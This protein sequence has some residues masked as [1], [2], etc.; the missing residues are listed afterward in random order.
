MRNSSSEAIFIHEIES[1]KTI[2]VNYAMLKMYGYN[3]IDEVRELNIGNLSAGT[4]KYTNDEAKK[5][6]KK[7][8]DEG[9]QYFEWIGKRKN[10]STFWL[11]V[12]L[13]K[14][15]IDNKEYVLAVARDISIRKTTGSG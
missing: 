7:A 1:G 13:K 3:S 14:T 11:E 4:G 2:D 6:I 15:T 10:N 8:V 9:P 12:T 5:L